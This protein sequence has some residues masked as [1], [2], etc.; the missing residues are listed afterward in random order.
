MEINNLEKTLKDYFSKFKQFDQTVATTGSDKTFYIYTTG[1]ADRNIIKI[2]DACR[3]KNIINQIPQNFNNIII[4]HY[5]PIEAP[6][7]NIT[8]DY[9]NDILKK[10]DGETQKTTQIFYNEYFDHKKIDTTKPYIVLDFASIY[11][12]NYDN[13]TQRFYITLQKDQK[14]E[15]DI[16]CIHIPY[17]I[18]FPPNNWCD[19]YYENI[20]Y[21][22]YDPVNNNITTFIQ[23]CFEKFNKKLTRIYQNYAI[24]DFINELY[25]KQVFEYVRGTKNDRVISTEEYNW[26]DNNIRTPLFMEF[27]EKLFNPFIDIKNIKSIVNYRIYRLLE[28]RFIPLN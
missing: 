24:T 5:D 23:L 18:E 7:Q 16:N 27:F 2:W 19:Y 11:Y 4:Y 3:Y 25:E 13:D 20:L 6:Q 1:L 28:K 8:I 26:L 12:Y 10:Q 17:P 22:T 9:I 14:I 21:F 15:V